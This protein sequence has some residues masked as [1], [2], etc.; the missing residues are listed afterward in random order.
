MYVDRKVHSQGVLD[1]GSKLCN[2]HSKSDYAIHILNRSPSVAV[3]E[4][5]PEEAWSGYKPSVD[6]LRVF[7]S[8]GYVHVPDVKR[9]KLD[10]K[11]VK[12]IRL[13][14]SGESKAYRLYNPET[15]KILI[16]RD[17]Q[18]AEN[19]EWDWKK[20]EEEVERDVL[21]WGEEED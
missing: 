5:T 4:A 17:V 8:I 12:C 7:G 15:K 20:S 13:G 14:L 10:E 9:S 1:G 3:K 6:H 19:E 2:S 18:F 11:S 21:E 16:S